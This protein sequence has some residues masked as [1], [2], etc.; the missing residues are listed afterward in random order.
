MVEGVLSFLDSV[1]LG[2][3][4]PAGEEATALR[5]TTDQPITP[6]VSTEAAARPAG[7]AASEEASEE[8]SG[9]TSGE[10]SEE[11]SGEASEEATDDKKAWLRPTTD[12]LAT[13]LAAGLEP[14]EGVPGLYLCRKENGYPILPPNP[15]KLTSRAQQVADAMRDELTAHLMEKGTKGL[16]TTETRSGEEGADLM[17]AWLQGAD[18]GKAQLKGANLRGA[19]LQ[20][21]NLGEAKLEGAEL[22]S[23]KLQGAELPAELLATLRPA[24]LEPREGVPGLFLRRGKGGYPIAPPD[25]KLERQAHELA[26]AMRDE[27]TAHLM[28][29]GT[30]GLPTTETRPGEE[31]ADLMGAWLQGANLDGKARAIAQLQGANFRGAQLQK[32][33]LRGVVL[34]KA[35]LQKAKLQGADLSRAKLK[36]ADLS[37]A[38][39]QE[40]KLVKAQLQG[41][42]L[43]K[44]QL[45]GANLFKVRLH[46]ANLT[47][48]NLAGADLASS[49]LAGADFNSADLSK[50]ILNEALESMR[51]YRP[52]HPP[53][54]L[55]S[56]SWRSKSV[57]KRLAQDDD[58]D[59]DDGD[60]GDSS[61]SEDDAGGEAKVA[62]WLEAA[63][64]VAAQAAGALIAVAQPVLEVVT[65]TVAELGRLCDA[66]A[67]RVPEALVQSLLPLL[68]KRPTLP[69]AQLQKVVV[70]RLKGL[71]TTCVLDSIFNK[72]LP[73]A[74]RAL[75]EQIEQLKLWMNGEKTLVMARATVELLQ[76]ELCTLMA[77]LCKQQLE[78]VEQFAKDFPPLVSAR[79]EATKTP[80]SANEKHET[81]QV[82]APAPAAV[83]S[84]PVEVD[85]TDQMQT[86]GKV[87]GE[88]DDDDD[89]DNGDNSA[90]ED[91]GDDGGEAEVAPRLEAAEDGGGSGCG[92]SRRGCTAQ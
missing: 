9:E 34:E 3:R 86:L 74:I 60:D 87:K 42:K 1:L 90:P 58:D 12:E 72:A 13:L 66:L 76:N 91:D 46:Q 49:K 65:S 50:A 35:N 45:R 37:E 92:C 15:I 11:A 48:A 62:P 16:P 5:P 41:A 39:L 52:P 32:A 51:N 84:T 55:A 20:K 10:T 83:S 70:V 6:S 44:A 47:R 81:D 33:I 25:V 18:L 64:E 31:G 85:T 68:K 19:K 2:S 14:R 59:D 21:A 57:A 56:S 22:P 53:A 8:A 73:G 88:S 36:G 71:L 78:L 77:E 80:V 38:Q 40:A 54:A 67:E 17:G 7:Q 79:A 63:E 69:A 30:K 82:S 26:T 24:G 89:D 61:G 4:P 23:V 28:K 75:K 27:L 43:Y 29:K